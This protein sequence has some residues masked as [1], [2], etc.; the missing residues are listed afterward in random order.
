M[1]SMG[2]NG[3]WSEYQRLVLAELERLNKNI[4]GVIRDQQSVTIII[5]RLQQQSSRTD[6]SLSNLGKQLQDHDRRLDNLKDNAITPDG[7]KKVIVDNTKDAKE[8]GWTN[9]QRLMGVALFVLTI[10]SFGLNVF[11]V[12]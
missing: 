2:G 5:D 6:S 10:I 7:V 1:S 9:N 3:G 11:Q 12:S 8:A 4:E